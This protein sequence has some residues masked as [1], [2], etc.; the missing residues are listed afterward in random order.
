MT[1]GQ[2]RFVHW[3]SGLSV[4]AAAAFLIVVPPIVQDESY[5]LFADGRMILGIPNF[6]N[7]VSNL[8]FATVG[9]LG[10]WKLRGP[11]NR[12]L[13]TGLLLTCFGSAYYHWAPTDSRLIWDRLPM[14]LV[15]MA[16]LT[17]LLSEGIGSRTTVRLHL[18]LL[19]CG[20][21]SVLWWSITN[22]LRPYLP[23][24]FGPM[25]FL[26]LIL[27]F[28]QGRRYLWAVIGLYALAKTPELSDRAIFSVL[29]VS[30]HSWK[31]ALAA[32]AAYSIYRWRL[33][34]QA[35][36]TS[37]SCLRPGGIVALRTVPS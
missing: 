36:S 1:T 27:R 21:G 35:E 31:H 3:I 19:V 18:V 15:F 4:T 30:G 17:P 11:V 23:V 32:L 20:T 25:L 24:Q 10:L 33:N 9:I 6:W 16:F 26:L 28:T 22:D 13:F 7:V 14:T 5:H 37:A 8:P 2:P 12:V 29:P 34:S